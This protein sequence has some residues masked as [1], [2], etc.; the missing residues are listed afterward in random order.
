MQLAQVNIIQDYPPGRIAD[1]QTLGGLISSFLP[2]IL[3]VA[4]I[5]FFILTVAAGV[6]VISG[7]G[8][9]NPQNQEKARSFLT[10]SVIGLVIIFASYWIVQLIS[11]ITFGSLKNLV[12]Q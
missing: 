1:F 9:G 11:F 10:Y 4:G 7:A 2:K 6:A 8:S 3:I 5:I 12:G